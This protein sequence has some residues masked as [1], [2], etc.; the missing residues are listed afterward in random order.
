MLFDPRYELDVIRLFMDVSRQNRLVVKW[1]GTVDGN[2]LIYAEQGFEDYRRIKI[3][4][5]DVTVVI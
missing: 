2:M 3:S 5:Y 4:D 1:C